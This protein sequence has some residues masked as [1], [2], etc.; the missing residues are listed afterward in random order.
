MIRTLVRILA[1][2]LEVCW[3]TLQDVVR[4]FLVKS[5][6]FIKLL[7]PGHHRQNQ[8]QKYIF[9]S[10]TYS[11][12]KSSWSLQLV[13]IECDPTENIFALGHFVLKCTEFF[14]TRY[15]TITSKKSELNR[16]LRTN[17]SQLSMVFSEALNLFGSSLRSKLELRSQGSFKA[18]SNVGLFD[19]SW[20]VSLSMKSQCLTSFL[21]F[22]L[23]VSLI[24][25]TAGNWELKEGKVRFQ[26]W[27]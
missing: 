16:K 5:C 4:I 13:N 7:R 9:V 3:L 26:T 19:G 8:S 22:K 14:E 12:D 17:S 21:Q 1:A 2:V 25:D 11:T 18:V 10:G 27:N 20:H 23:P 24:I 15:Q 6:K